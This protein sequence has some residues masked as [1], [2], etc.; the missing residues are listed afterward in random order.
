MPILPSLFREKT[1]L[2]EGPTYPF[3]LFVPGEGL[4]FRNRHLVYY[5]GYGKRPCSRFPLKGPLEL[6]KGKL[7]VRQPRLRLL[8]AFEK[9]FPDIAASHRSSGLVQE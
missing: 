9:G 2:P 1:Q 3:G 5:V 6:Q 8:H 4:A 7:Q